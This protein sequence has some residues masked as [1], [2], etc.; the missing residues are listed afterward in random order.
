[1]DNPNI[2]IC[3]NCLPYHIAYDPFIWQLLWPKWINLEMRDVLLC[4]LDRDWS[5]QRGYDQD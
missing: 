3:V 4:R 2:I 5:E 1:M